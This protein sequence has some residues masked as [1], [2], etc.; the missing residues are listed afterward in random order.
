MNGRYLVC[1]IF[2]LFSVVL[3]DVFYEPLE[4]KVKSV[5]GSDVTCISNEEQICFFIGSRDDGSSNLAFVKTVGKSRSLFRNIY[6][7]LL[8]C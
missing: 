3:A 7:Y 1:A 8:I 4:D 2:L 6:T 5:G